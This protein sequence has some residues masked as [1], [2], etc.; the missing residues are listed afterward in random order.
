MTLD[1]MSDNGQKFREP[2][3]HPHFNHAEKII[4]PG[5]NVNVE[6]EEAV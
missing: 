2:P 5:K 6:I 1:G 3:G 4:K